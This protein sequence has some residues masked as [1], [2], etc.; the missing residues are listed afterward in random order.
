MELGHRRPARRLAPLHAG[1]L[2][3]GDVQEGQQDAVADQDAGLRRL[4]DVP[5]VPA[6]RRCHGDR[7]GRGG[8]VVLCPVQGLQVNCWEHSWSREKIVL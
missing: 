5:H 2:Q 7:E 1:R 6:Q 3:P 4:Q 8:G